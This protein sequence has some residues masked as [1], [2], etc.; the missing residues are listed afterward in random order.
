MPRLKLHLAYTGTFFYGWQIQPNKRTVQGCLEKEISK[1]CNIHI[2]VHGSGRTD[3]GVHALGQVAHC[4]IPSNKV[5]IPWQKALNSLLPEDITVISAKWVNPDFHA[6][7]STTGKEYSYSL[8]TNPDFVIP[9]RRPF[10]WT[11]GAVDEKK[12]KEAAEILL[13]KHDF[14]AFQNVGTPIKNKVRTI[15]WIKTETGYFSDEKIWRFSADGFLKQM[16]RNLISCLVSIGKNNLNLFELQSILDS[17][18]RSFAPATAP[19]KGLC[20]EQVF[21]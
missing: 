14:S 13:G 20:L 4:D 8:W 9:Q 1:I 3:T 7:F 18:E 21:Y 5:N 19:A 6:R 2:R 16:V 17:R 11:V 12:M 15:Y 10:V